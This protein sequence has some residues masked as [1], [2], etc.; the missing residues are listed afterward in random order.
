[1]VAKSNNAFTTY[2]EA[3]AM[4]DVVYTELLLQIDLVVLL[5]QFS[6]CVEVL[7]LVLAFSLPGSWN[8]ETTSAATLEGRDADLQLP[9]V[10]LSFP[11]TTVHIE[12]RQKC[13]L[14]VKQRV[15]TAG[16]PTALLPCANMHAML[17]CLDDWHHASPSITTQASPAASNHENCHE[18]YHVRVACGNIGG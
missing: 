1:M 15:N 12:L 16:R 5:H 11:V 8:S 2:N 9:F 4:F 14:S 6:K 13:S 3:V 17:C 18:A 7:A 10:K